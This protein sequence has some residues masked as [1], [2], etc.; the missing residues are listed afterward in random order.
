MVL[1]ASF[2][3]DFCPFRTAMDDTYSTAGPLP[4]PSFAVIG[5]DAFLAARPATPV[6]V[7]HACS[8]AGYDATVPAT[9]GDELIAARCIE[10]LAE[11]TLA[12]AIFCACSLVRDRLLAPGPDLL[13]F[14]LS[15]VSPPVAAARYLR[16]LYAGRSVD[17]TYVGACPSADDEAI[18]RVVTPVAFFAELRAR[19]ISLSHQPT[20]FDSTFAPDRRRCLSQPGGLPAPA[21][22]DNHVIGRRITE[23]GSFEYAAD[24]AQHLILSE[25]VLIDISARAGCACAGAAI[26]VPP[27]ETRRTVVALEPPRSAQ[28]IVEPGVQVMIDLP[29]APPPDGDGPEPTYGEP[30]SNDRPEDD[31]AR[32]T[33]GPAP[34][35]RHAPEAV[36]PRLQPREHSREQPRV[37]RR[38]GPGRRVFDQTFDV[39]FDSAFREAFEG[40]LDRPP[41]H[42]IQRAEPLVAVAERTMV[43]SVL[44]MRRRTER[45]VPTARVTADDG[46]PVAL[47]RAYVARRTPA[48]PTERLIPIV[49]IETMAPPPEPIVPIVPV[50]TL[51]LEDQ[52]VRIPVDREPP[53]VRA[54]RATARPRPRAPRLAEVRR[55]P[56]ADAWHRT[57]R[58]F[59]RIPASTYIISFAAVTAAAVFVG[60]TV[61]A[62]H[63]FQLTAQQPH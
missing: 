4:R 55:H 25:P 35:V 51:R 48:T 56:V 13:P 12:P 33:D 23:I 7:V 54:V 6:Q 58:W 31:G 27:L 53:S 22:L 60:I 20:V 18:D 5:A 14:V 16:Q 10:R 57:T 17:I 2:V 62:R 28:P 59:R 63:N 8:R 24:L 29:L 11:R 49:P 39:Q 61:R 21:L 42:A 37:E 46:R 30:D 9:W 52:I 50:Q 34:S 40:A 47:P 44:A 1:S 19:G 26:G 3:T 38:A 36:Q 41:V 43:E 45:R 15:F 32:V